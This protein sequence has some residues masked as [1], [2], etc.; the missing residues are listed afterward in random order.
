MQRSI[1]A[2][3]VAVSLGACSSDSDTIS[4]GVDSVLNSPD[5][6]DITLASDD[7]TVLGDLTELAD[8]P[9]NAGG[10]IAAPEPELDNDADFA[11]NLNPVSEAPSDDDSGT[12][13]GGNAGSG[14]AGGQSGSAAP[15]N[16]STDS[17]DQDNDAGGNAGS[18][19]D[20]NA[21]TDQNDA[22]QNTGGGVSNEP[23]GN[24]VSDAGETATESQDN[25]GSPGNPAEQETGGGIS[26]DAGSATS[27]GGE[28]ASEQTASDNADTDNSQDNAAEQDSAG[29]GIS[30]DAGSATSDGGET[31]SGNPDANDSQ[32]DSAEQD[33]GGGI[34]DDAGGASSDGE[35]ASG[36]PDAD[37]GGDDPAEQDSGGGISDDAGSASSDGGE[38][39]SGNPDADGGGDGP[40]EQDSGGGISD[41]AGSASSDGGETASDSGNGISD[42]A[43]SASSDGGQSPADDAS[44]GDGGNDATGGESANNDDNNSNGSGGGSAEQADASDFESDNIGGSVIRRSVL[45]AAS[46]QVN[47]CTTASDQDN[48]SDTRIG[49]FILHNNA[50]RPGR[51]APGYPWTQCIYTNTNGALAGW[52]YDWGPGIIGSNGNASGDFYVRSYPELIFGVKDE[53]RTSAPK[54]VTGLPVLLS[55]LPNITIDYSYSG[56]QYGDPREV[57]AS[58]NPRF[59]NGTEISGER[60]IAIESFL[61]T[62][63][64][65]GECSENIVTRS[66]G[67]SNHQ[68]E[69]MVWLDAGAE[70]LPAGP[71]DFVTDVNIRGE[72]FKVYTKDSDERYIAFVAQNPQT[73]GTLVW[74]DFTDWARTYAHR[75]GDVFGARSESVQIQDSWCVANILVGTEIFWGRGNLDLF[76]WTITQSR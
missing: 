1:V 56:P 58:N 32:D 70:R 3:V 75:V 59:P 47:I 25:A 6:A 37:G 51:A 57:T 67:G 30:D 27:D 63:D 69:V 55:E 4:N 28:T 64:A 41:D 49:D 2:A 46:S 14:D 22:D 62:P 65:S 18:D 45:S 16:S 36:N 21:G 39:A 20:N 29:G 34:S 5:S 61:Y 73:S 68:Y 42:D 8:E 19:A 60:N 23:A 11:D 66:E 50:W 53:F 44:A 31:A 12:G 26:D 72:A 52:E 54:S 71:S 7:S 74:N 9:D 76:E 43:G 38:T 13:G 10:Q 24:D 40:A 17:Q 33:S 35:T 15:D 48:F